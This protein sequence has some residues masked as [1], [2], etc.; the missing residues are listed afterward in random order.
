MVLS[1]NFNDSDEYDKVVSSMKKGTFKIIK[2]PLFSKQ[3]KLSVIALLFSKK[4]YNKLVLLNND[5][6]MSVFYD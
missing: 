6:N 4:L 1:K 2:N 3:R 5:Q